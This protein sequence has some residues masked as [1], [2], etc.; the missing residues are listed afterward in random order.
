MVEAMPDE[1]IK[2]QIEICKSKIDT[3]SFG[4][5]VMDLFNMLP[6]NERAEIEKIDGVCKVS[7]SYVNR[8]I[9][10]VLITV[11]FVTTKTYNHKLLLSEILK[12]AES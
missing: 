8:F 4:P 6:E 7:E 10:N 3:E 11:E 2:H 9:N 12:R 5:C 1:A